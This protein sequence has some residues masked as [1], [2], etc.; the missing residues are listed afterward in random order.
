[1]L[2]GVVIALSAAVLVIAALLLISGTSGLAV[3]LGWVGVQAAIVLVAVLA[4]RGRYRPAAG[5]GRWVRT[6]E[7]FQD[8][9]SRRWLLVEYNPATGERRY[10]ETEERGEWRKK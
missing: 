9:T 1:M 2:R 4:E 7:R 6:A 3:A 5:E 10:V 8:P